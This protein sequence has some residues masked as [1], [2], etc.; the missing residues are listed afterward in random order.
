MTGV[1]RLGIPR[2][3]CG[4]V[5][6]HPCLMEDERRAD[7]GSGRVRLQL[8]GGYEASVDGRPIAFRT[9]KSFALFAY[10]AL[11]PRPHRRES[12]AELLWPGG[13][14]TD[15]RANLRTALAYVRGAI[16][17]RADA[18]LLANREFVG[19]APG[20]VEVDVDVLRTARQFRRQAPVALRQQ[21][22]CA[23]SHYRGP[24]LAELV[25]PDA[26]ELEEW[27]EAQRTYWRNVATELLCRL[28]TL[29]EALGDL[30]LA[31][32]TLEWWTEIN[33]D[34]EQAW[35]R[36]IETHANRNDQLAARHAW[37]RYRA[38]IRELNVA[39]S[40]PMT[41]LY[42][43]VLGRS[44]NPRSSKRQLGGWVRPVAHAFAGA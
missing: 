12:I 7:A 39:P 38:A 2:I 42:E 6:P 29:Q 15:A 24:F 14:G 16:G 1:A 28:A 5:L 19:V 27:I 30:A 37:D 13:D 8:L 26:P 31:V 33:R 35:Q 22:E 23:V 44:D 11:D 18:I 10:L 43:R 36:L 34:E 40:E 41:R 21:L 9:R 25:F 4:A 17:D 32:G 3:R 20:S